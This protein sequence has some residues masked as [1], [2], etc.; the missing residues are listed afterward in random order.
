MEDKAGGVVKNTIQLQTYMKH[1]L[2]YIK[3][4]GF[5]E[6][7]LEKQELTLKRFLSW[8]L[9]RE[10]KD[11]REIT[12]AVLEAYQRKLFYYRMANG[13]PLS[14]VTQNNVMTC[15][16][17]WLQWLVRENHIAFNP[18]EQ[19]ELARLPRKLP[20]KH[21][22]K[23]EIQK[24][25]NVP[26]IETPLGIRDRAILET[27][28]STGMR[29]S[30]L[31][32]LKPG[33]ID[34]HEGVIYITGKGGHQRV[35]PIGENALNWIKKYYRDVRPSYDVVHGVE[36]LFLYE[37]GEAMIKG[38]I[39][40]LVKRLMKKAGINKE[41]S[42]HLLRH[43]CAS[44]LLEAGMDVRLIQQL[45]G[46]VKAETTAIYAKVSVGYLKRVHGELSG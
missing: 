34:F 4:K 44:H 35:V 9:Q 6:R 20:R 16:K 7:T 32:R 10:I 28:Y 36:N 39:S 31:M 21:L 13:K 38:R 45:L 15:V 22:N 41:G 11:P 40:A 12:R 24:L 25:M 46:H 19:I 3:I 37:N 23:S 30:E 26:D 18:A 5:S 1:Y 29:R 2:E 14:T 17:S 27:F 42:C 43:S 8:C 33:D